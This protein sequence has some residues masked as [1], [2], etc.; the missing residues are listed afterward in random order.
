[1][2]LFNT[3][4]ITFYITVLLAFFGIVLII[5]RSYEDKSKAMAPMLITGLLIWAWLTLHAFLANND[6]YLQVEEMP[7]RLLLAPLPPLLFI[8]YV[9]IFKKRIMLRLP[10][11][12]MTFFHVVRVPVE[13]VL[14]GLFLEG[15][16]PELMT[17]TGRNF[18]ILVGLTA[19][20][21]AML[22]YSNTSIHK[23]W[24]VLWNFLGLALLI[25]VVFHGIFST[26]YPFQLFGEEQANIAVLQ[27]PVIWLPAFIVPAVAFFHIACLMQLLNKNHPGY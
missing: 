9:A 21:M 3:V 16:I 13:L 23:P 4:Y 1:M 10:G 6:F 22:F 25:N 8:I 14:Y 5:Y 15:Q 18:D 12:W 7:P 17:F 27:Y 24:M 20:V 26:P 2:D 11:K 19:P